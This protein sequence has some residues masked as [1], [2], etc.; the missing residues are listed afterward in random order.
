MHQYW[1]HAQVSL[2][3]H[4]LLPVGG[5]GADTAGEA[6]PGRRQEQ[7]A[8]AAQPADPGQEQQGADREEGAGAGGAGPGQ[9]ATTAVSLS[10]AG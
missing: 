1:L 5:A 8:P 3:E 7:G 9:A 2:S 4:L 6:E 10:Q